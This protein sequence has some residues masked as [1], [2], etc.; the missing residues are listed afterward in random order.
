MNFHTEKVVIALIS[1]LGVGLLVLSLI[2]MYNDFIQARPIMY[3]II[4]FSFLF[5]AVLII[6]GALKLY[7]RLMMFALLTESAFEEII[8]TKLKP[9]LEEIAFGTVELNEVK[10]RVLGLERKIGHIEEELTKPK[11]EVTHVADSLA[12]KKTAFYMRTIV[13]AM[14]FFGMYLFLLEYSVPYEPYLYVF[15]YVL[16]WFFVTKEFN[17][18]NRIE[19]WIVLGTPILLVPAGA[20]ILRAVFGLVPLMGFIF[21]TVIIY[22]YLYY[23]YATA[24]SEGATS[25]SRENFLYI[26]I[27]D[28]IRKA[29]TWLKS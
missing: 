11:P 9:L 13:A 19:A 8:Y 20:I 3:L 17:L 16:W 26:K 15:L 1:L 24:L 5:I 6:G 4:D 2:S 23:Q 22:A 25:G 7:K 29:I 12:L 28:A 10:T 14:L 18:F 21:L 27:K